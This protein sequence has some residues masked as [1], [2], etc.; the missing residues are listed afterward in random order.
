MMVKQDNKILDIL[1][2]EKDILIDFK[3]LIQNMLKAE[4]KYKFTQNDMAKLDFSN[5][6]IINSLTKQFTA[7]ELGLLIVITNKIGNLQ[8]ALQTFG[9]LDSTRK[10]KLV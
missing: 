3:D 2:F 1:K 10:Q 8:Q 5:K 9:Q 4:K 6:S 7:D